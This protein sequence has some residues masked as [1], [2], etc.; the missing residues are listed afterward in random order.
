LAKDNE[1][2][3]KETE[4]TQIQMDKLTKENQ[5]LTEETKNLEQQDQEDALAP[6]VFDFSNFPTKTA[7]IK[8][9][10]T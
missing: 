10:I 3:L 4:Q 1:R 9:H 6:K 7:T 8:L 5:R 2:L